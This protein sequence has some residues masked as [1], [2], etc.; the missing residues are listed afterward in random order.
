VGAVRRMLTLQDREEISRGIAE[1][2]TGKEIA[3]RIGRCGTFR[4]DRG[5][6][7]RLGPVASVPRP[8]RPAGTADR[9]ATETR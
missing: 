9:S 7:L 3:V 4:L 6:R 2:L 1:N 8:R 5:K